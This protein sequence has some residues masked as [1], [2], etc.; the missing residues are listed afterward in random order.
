[1]YDNYISI[2][3]T[4]GDLIGLT[5]IVKGPVQY[6][7]EI[8]DEIL[9]IIP[10]PEN[11]VI[12]TQIEFNN[13]IKK[14]LPSADSEDYIGLKSTNGKLVL[15]VI[16]KT[17]GSGIRSQCPATGT[18]EQ[19]YFFASTL[20]TIVTKTKDT[21]V[22]IQVGERGQVLFCGSEGTIGYVIKPSKIANI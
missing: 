2:K 7:Q 20:A 9:D 17:K 10:I 18:M 8:P 19:L 14:V 15:D 11:P 6:P 3:R 4:E 22:W 12:V 13:A 5:M 16:N 1:M 21:E